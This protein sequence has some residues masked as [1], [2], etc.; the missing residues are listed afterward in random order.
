MLLKLFEHQQGFAWH[1]S[2]RAQVKGVLFDRD[3]E[4]CYAQKILEYFAIADRNAFESR[5]REANGCFAVVVETEQYLFAAVD[6]LRS[7]PLF[8]AV[9][10]KE[11][12]LG[13]DVY[14]IQR[15]LG[16]EEP[17]DLIAR[18]EFLR[19]G[20]AVGPRT[21]DSRIKQ[22]EAGEFLVYNKNTGAVDIH[23]YFSHAHGNYT[24]QSEDPLIDEL[25]EIT[26]RWAKRLIQSV[27]G[28]TIVVPLS[29]GYDSRYIACALKREGFEKVVCYSY[30]SPE[31]FEWHV[32]RDVA[33]RLGYPIHIIEYNRSVWRATIESPRFVDFC[34]LA[35]QR[36]AVPCIQEL[37]AH[38]ILAAQKAIPV[39]SVIVP[40]YCGDVLGGSFIPPEV[41]RNRTKDL[42]AKG[43]DEYLFRTQ[44]NLLAAPISTNVRQTILEHIHTVTFRCKSRDVDSF[45]S[46]C[47]EWLTQNRW[48]K[49]IVNAVRAYEFFG[50]EWRLPLWD[51]E[52]IRWWY[53]IP[54][55]LRV[56][57][58]LYH[59]FL[60]ERVF[61]PMGVAFH[62]PPTSTDA[63]LAAR[64]W[65]PAVLFPLARW[66]YR[67]TLKKAVPKPVDIDAFNDAAEIL[68]EQLPG[69]WRL[70][71]FGNINGVFA[72][73][74]DAHGF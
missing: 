60:F 62:K 39:D 20:Y 38:E 11:L 70:T 54:L 9:N 6:P 29:G 10:D 43:P 69:K 52:L 68:L 64:R 40:G 48:S 5:L 47:E 36:C 59:Q 19:V 7:I 73:W 14:A 16:G 27:A 50:H 31:S 13:D 42:L 30:G 3:G 72:S 45:C 12:V 23:L 51:T 33:E 55:P 57:S 71:D 37:P 18:E 44:F 2:S 41:C 21:M 28:R 58:V 26:S 53:R 56:N 17:T 46:A 15:E 49:F 67:R 61:E 24:D 32:A 35:A 22:L 4:L 66:L 74:C 65:L 1:R 34:R 8:Y 63:G 25:D